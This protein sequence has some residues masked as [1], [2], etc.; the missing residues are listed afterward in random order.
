MRIDSSGN[1]LVGTTDTTIYNDSSDEYGFMV[2]PSGQMQLSA[3][4]ATMLYLNRQNGD[5]TIIDFRKDGSAVGSIASKNGENIIVGSSDCAISFQTGVL[6]PRTTTDTTSDNALDLGE[7]GSRFK[8][9]YLGGSVYLGG[10]TSANAL[11]DYEEGTH[12]TAITC[13]TSG[14]ITLGG[15]TEKLQYTK[16][17]RLVTVTGRVAVSGVSSPTGNFT[18]SL[19]FTIADLDEDSGRSTG[20]IKIFNTSTNVDNFFFTAHEGNA[21]ITVYKGGS[22]NGTSDS[23]DTFSGNEAIALSITYVAS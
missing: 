15:S 21:F 8:D 14:T 17:G 11:D 1:L 7:S 16:I 20:S 3:N 2:E 6:R 19:P 23:A 9:L 12:D 13:G 5:G 4:N 10:T 18:M 22:T